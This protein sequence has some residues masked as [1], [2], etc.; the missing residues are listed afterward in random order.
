[1][2]QQK[3]DTAIRTIFEIINSDGMEGLSEAGSILINEAMKVE[4]SSALNAQPWQRTE[5]RMVYANGFKNKSVVSRLGKL[6]L[7]IPLVHGD[8]EFYL[9]ALETGIRSEKALTLA[10]QRCMSRE[11]QHERSPQ[12]LKNYADSKSAA[13]RSAMLQNFWTKNL[14]NGVP[15]Q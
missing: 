3:E 11:S 6:H 4:R 1:M 9:S 13:P 5:S 2:T 12:F 14:K 15:D 10:W 8:V 7:N